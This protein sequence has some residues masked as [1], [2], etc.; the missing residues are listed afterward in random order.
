MDGDARRPD[1]AG[2]I[3][4]GTKMWITS[5][6]LADV[7]VVWAK[8]DEGIRGFL[9]PRGTHG[10]PRRNRE[11]DLVASIGD[12]GL[13]F[14]DVRV[15]ADA[16]LPEAT[17]LSWPLRCLNEARFGIIWGVM[18]AAR[19]CFE[20]ALDYPSVTR[21]QFGKPIG[22]LSANAEQACRHVA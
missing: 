22:W 18:G 1:G 7:A 13:I 5:G 21:E 15:P 4:N 3:L 16:I 19:A 2:W 20:S 17:G 14:D 10:L 6:S 9:V 11:E 8:T 12:F